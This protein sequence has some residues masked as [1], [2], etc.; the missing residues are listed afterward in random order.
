MSLW[1]EVHCPRTLSDLVGHE[2]VRKTLGSFVHTSQLPHL[3]LHGSSGSGKTASI[4]ALIHDLFGEKCESQ[5]LELNASEQR[6]IKVIRDTVADFAASQQPLLHS[7]FNRRTSRLKLIVLDEADNLTPDAQ[8]CLRRLMEVYSATTRFCFLCNYA[9]RILPALRSR[10]CEFRFRPVPPDAVAA[11]LAY[12][13]AKEGITLDQ[14]AVIAIQQVAAGD[15]RRAL[16]IFQNVVVGES[17]TGGEGCPDREGIIT[18]AQVYRVAAAPDPL[19]VERLL[20]YCFNCDLR[21][22]FLLLKTFVRNGSVCPTNLVAAFGVAIAKLD[23]IFAMPLTV[24]LAD[25]EDMACRENAN[26]TALLAALAA[27]V[28]IRV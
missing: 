4:H 3:L 11:R 12:V 25:V 28:H 27:A 21:Q 18:A 22:R 9:G 26:G 10:C 17:F 5:V 20:V 23:P 24:A 19:D 7:M 14:Q 16:G 13:A 1:S 2:D 8:C 15:L 6:S